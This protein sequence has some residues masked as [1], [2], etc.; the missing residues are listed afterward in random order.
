MLHLSMIPDP[1]VRLRGCAWP[2]VA[3]RGFVPDET[4]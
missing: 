3:R 1:V 2:V 4:T